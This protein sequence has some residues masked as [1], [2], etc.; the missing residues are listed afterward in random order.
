MGK[1]FITCALL[2]TNILAIGQSYNFHQKEGDVYW[3]MI[4]EADI[5]IIM[6]LN[7]SGNFEQ[8]NTFNGITTARIVP[9]KI[10]L[11]GRSAP[12]VPI[13]LSQSNM[14]GFVKIQQKD[15]RYRVTVNQIVFFNNNSSLGSID[16]S[17]PLETYATK[18]DGTFKP[19][20]LNSAAEILNE[21]LTAMF[22]PET[23][24]GDDW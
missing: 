1:F 24:L 18:R 19:I 16:E 21:A 22:T 20:F 3:Q 4:Y 2:L 5:D 17:T 11:N 14:T 9:R 6:M 10:N 8:I 15:K 12:S 23:D 7:M 13:Y